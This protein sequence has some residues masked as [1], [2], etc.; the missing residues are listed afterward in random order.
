[1][2]TLGR[3]SNDFRAKPEEREYHMKKNEIATFT[4]SSFEN[5]VLSATEDEFALGEKVVRDKALTTYHAR[6]SVLITAKSISDK[7]LCI[8]CGRVTLE[9]VEKVGYSTVPAFINDCFGSTLDTNTIQRYIRIGKV[10][11]DYTADGYKWKAPISQAVSVTNLGQ[12]I[13][14][15]FEDVP[16]DKRDVYKLSATEL[17]NLFD[18]FCEKYHPDMDNGMPLQGTN[19]A[20][21]KYLADLKADKDTIP[22]TAEDVTDNEPSAENEPTADEFAKVKAEDDAKFERWTL[23]LN[24]IL[25]CFADDAEVETAVIKVMELVHIV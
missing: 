25:A 23:A 13:A 21:R 14:L 4:S 6:A 24:E 19:K 8:E 16:K 2:L 18:A 5:L 3:P 17:N 9:D 20:L 11:G 15:V 22:T 12:I 1:M 7:A 10:F